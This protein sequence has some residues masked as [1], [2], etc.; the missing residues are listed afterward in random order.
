MQ[1]TL[2]DDAETAAQTLTVQLMAIVDKAT[3]VS[4]NSVSVAA[5]VCAPMDIYTADVEFAVQRFAFTI[6]VCKQNNIRV[7]IVSSGAFRIPIDITAGISFENYALWEPIAGRSV[8][9]PHLPSL[10]GIPV[11]SQD[12]V[13][14]VDSGEAV[15]LFR[16]GLQSFLTARFKA[17]QSNISQKPG[18]LFTVSTVTLGLRVHYSPAFFFNPNNVFGSPT[19]PVSAWI[20][21]GKYVFGAVGPHTPLKFDMQA[22][23]TIP[24]QTDAQLNI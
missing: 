9:E 1:V 8:L 20:Q 18:L 24:P 3:A 23:Y 21:P 22:H 4:Q 16:G 15:Q 7:P 13:S 6:A 11:L 12:E 5:M 2:I 10:F 14:V 19:T 17:R